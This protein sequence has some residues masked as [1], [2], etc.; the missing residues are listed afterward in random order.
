MLAL[1]R[2]QGKAECQDAQA[3]HGHAGCHICDMTS[4]PIAETLCRCAQAGPGMLVLEGITGLSRKHCA[5][6][7]RVQG[8]FAD[9]GDF[10][11][12]HMLAGTTHLLCKVQSPLNQTRVLATCRSRVESHFCCVTPRADVYCFNF[13][14]AAEDVS[15]NGTYLNGKRLPRPPYKNPSDTWLNGCNMPQQEAASAF[16]LVMG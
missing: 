4:L 1:I 5:S 2:L 9:G 7:S 12:K 13:C 14:A 16:I 8:R 11:F 6:V 10:A 15:T 3:A